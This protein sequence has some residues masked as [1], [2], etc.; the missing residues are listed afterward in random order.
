MAGAVFVTADDQE[1][2]FRPDLHRK[3]DAAARRYSGS[4]VQ[5]LHAGELGTCAEALRNVELLTD[6][7][8]K[9][10]KTIAQFDEIKSGRFE[11]RTWMDGKCVCVCVCVCLERER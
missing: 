7:V 4:A 6:A 2:S 3:V 10:I 1:S 5:I 8:A 11:G 9:D